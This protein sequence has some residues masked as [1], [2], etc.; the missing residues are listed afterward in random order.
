MS[1]TEPGGR[2]ESQSSGKISIYS[3]V[4]RGQM[5]AQV[6]LPFPFKIK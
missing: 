3:K 4:R 1:L 5:F 6:I 2:P